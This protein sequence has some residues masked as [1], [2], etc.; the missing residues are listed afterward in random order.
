M[1]NRI[2]FCMAF[3]GGQV[4]VCVILFVFALSCGQHLATWEASGCAAMAWV[5]AGQ[6]G[7]QWLA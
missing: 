5:L 2:S 1:P 6:A 4:Y 7:L 3:E